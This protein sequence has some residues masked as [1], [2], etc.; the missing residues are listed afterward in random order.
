MHP[1]LAWSNVIQEY[2]T[3]NETKPEPTVAYFDCKPSTPLPSKS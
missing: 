1:F 3:N 2:Q